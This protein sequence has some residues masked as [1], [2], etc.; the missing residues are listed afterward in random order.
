MVRMF[1]MH[2]GV[3]RYISN[4]GLDRGHIVRGGFLISLSTTRCSMLF[5]GKEKPGFGPYHPKCK[6]LQYVWCLLIINIL[7]ECKRQERQDIAC[8]H[9]TSELWSGSDWPASRSLKWT[10]VTHRASLEEVRNTFN[11]K[12]PEASVRHGL[13]LLAQLSTKQWIYS[14]VST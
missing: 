14:R 8:S 7:R 5:M 11:K 2:F 6:G 12:W 1:L 4:I 3:S 9:F 13:L 10:K